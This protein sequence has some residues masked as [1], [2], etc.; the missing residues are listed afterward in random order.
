MICEPMLAGY[1]FA[2]IAAS[3]SPRPQS[4]KR[5]GLET[6]AEMTIEPG[7]LQFQ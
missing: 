4:E 5:C 6:T 2:R 7:M 3:V 1:R